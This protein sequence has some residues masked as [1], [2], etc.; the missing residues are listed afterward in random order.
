LLV[1]CDVNVVR[2]QCNT[3][4]TGGAVMG[5]PMQG[6]YVSGPPMGACDS[7]CYG[8]ACGGAPGCGTTGGG[9][10]GLISNPWVVGGVVAAAIAIPLALDDD[11]DNAS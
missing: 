1:V 7:G 6:G 10:L 3:C 9:F 4:N 2:G 11:N 8:G 5:P